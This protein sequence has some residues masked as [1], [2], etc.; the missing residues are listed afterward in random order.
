MLKSGSNVLTLLPCL[1]LKNKMNVEEFYQPLYQSLANTKM[2]KWL[3]TLP[4]QIAEKLNPDNHGDFQRWEKVIDQL[5]N[6]IA[7]RINL[8]ESSIR[9]N[10]NNNVEENPELKFLLMGLSPWRKGPYHFHGVDIDTEWRSDLKWDRLKNAI[11]PLKNR[12]VLDVGCG[13]GYHCWRMRGAG[14]RT[15]VGID[16][17]ILAVLQYHVARHF[18][19]EQQVYVLPLRIEDLPAYLNGFDTVFSMGVLYHRRSPLDHLLD[20]KNCLRP[21][22]ELVLESLVIEGDANQVLVPENRYAK[23]S[24]VWFL[25]SSDM[26]Y[27]WLIRC[28]FKD[29]TLVDVSQTTTQEQRQT[30]WMPFESFQDFVHPEHSNLTIEGLPAPRRAIFTAQ[31]PE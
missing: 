15:V 12:W 26:L 9:V 31:K 6:L 5:P 14:A 22:G 16:P 1:P 4:E 7:D 19:G 27:R 30:E 13:N 17:S 11:T 23:M 3:D 29:V 2:R 28:G 18:I 10:Q 21:G 20:L 25:P 24:N 8:D